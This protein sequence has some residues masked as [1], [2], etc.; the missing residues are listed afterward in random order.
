MWN[1]IVH[2]ILFT[3]VRHLLLPN[4]MQ[5]VW[6]WNYQLADWLQW[7]IFFPPLLNA[8][9]PAPSS[10]SRLL[11]HI[12]RQPSCYLGR[13]LSFHFFFLNWNESCILLE[14]KYKLYFFRVDK[15]RNAIQSTSSKTITFNSFPGDCSPLVKEAL[16]NKMASYQ[17]T[18]TELVQR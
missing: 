17:Q 6:F 14:T 8:W 18:T 4:N 10:F 1:C 9:H 12:S 5:P 16:R 2:L 13:H 7:K 3:C 15:E 11:C